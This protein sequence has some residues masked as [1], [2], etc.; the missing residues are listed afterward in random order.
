LSHRGK[1]V[2]HAQERFFNLIEGVSQMRTFIGVGDV[3]TVKK[4]GLGLSVAINKASY[5]AKKFT[6]SGKDAR[7]PIQRID[8]L[9]SG[10]G[11]EVTVDLLMPMNMDPVIGEETLS[12][13]EQQLKYYTDRLRID[14][15]RAGADRGSRMTQKRTVRDLRSDAKENLTG[16][17]KRLL[18]EL[19]F[20]YLSGTAGTGTGMVWSP[21]NSFFNVNALTAPDTKHLMYG[22]VATSKASL[23][24]TDTM[25]LRLV[26]RGVARAQTMGG[27]G[28]GELSMV[29]I[30][31]NGGEHYVM[32]MHPF[33]FDAMK[34]ST[35]TGQWLDIQKAAAA[36]Q[37]T[38]NPIFSGSKGMYNDVV[39][40]THRNVIQF[41]DYGAGA[42]LPA[43]RALFLA[44]QAAFVAYGSNDGEMR[45]KWT[46]ES[47][48]HE[49]S[50]AFGTNSVMGVKKATYKSK[51]GVTIR[52]FG[53]I[54]MDTYAV[55]PG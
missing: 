33:Q 34:S 28:S 41:A 10:P 13:K 24:T 49:N 17:W 12:G 43:A 50:V 30:E 37:G 16:Y 20:I 26:D 36:A 6:G 4:W 3:Q 53:V 35:I 7:L 25:N 52:D 54:A 39:L 23:A 9:Q 40:E 15:V 18:D 45:M 2:N 5:F 51:D 29:P 21:T 47:K 8:D 14:Q 19:Y 55:D 27:D 48:D 22:G 42:N 44:S 46:E 1:P 32:L 38:N 11:D 31:V